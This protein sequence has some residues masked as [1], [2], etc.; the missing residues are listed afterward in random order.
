MTE[1][2][3]RTA[4]PD[5]H[6]VSEYIRYASQQTD[7]SHEYHEAVAL[8]LL[9]VATP[10]VVAPIAQ[11]PLGLR[12]NLYLLLVG[13]TS[14][15]RKS[16]A[17]DIGKDLAKRVW[18]GV[19]LNEK[20]TPEAFAQD[21][22]SRSARSSLWAVDEFAQMLVQMHKRDFMTGLAGL[23]LEVYSGADYTYQRTSK[24]S[25]AITAPHL[26]LVGC[27]ADTIFDKLHEDDVTSGLLPRF[28]I[29]MP[30]SKPARMAFHE[31]HAN[32]TSDANALMFRLNELSPRRDPAGALIGPPRS[33]T[34]SPAALD[35]I[36]QFGA[37]CEKQTGEL[38]RRL[39]PMAM[40]VAMLSAVGHKFRL[41]PLVVSG[42]DAANAVQVV[43]RWAESAAVFQ[44][45]LGET[46][47]E[48]LVTR[49]LALAWTKGQ[50]TGVPVGRRLLARLL[51]VDAKSMAEA[52]KTLADR[53]HIAVEKM[54]TQEV[55][56]VLLDEKGPTS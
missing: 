55:V 35:A 45:K 43:R 13:T 36:D 2:N 5:D 48:K 3:F 14:L 9:S 22:A 37:E 46:R 20:S 49:A 27:C 30:T 17:K 19:L 8:A 47:L 39:A 38:F 50:K 7:A 18:P 10:D 40:K 26:S 1:Y 56:W 53:G 42:D 41:D 4:F 28:G 32:L 54:Q 15:S 16:T 21:L 6:F 33:I 34:F 52:E 44:R 24:P 29:V 11:F 12:T 23:L 31:T 51:H 25:V